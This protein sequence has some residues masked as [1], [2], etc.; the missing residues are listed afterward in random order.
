MVGVIARRFILN[1]IGS[2]GDARSAVV[3]SMMERDYCDLIPG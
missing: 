3:L 1:Y 2:V